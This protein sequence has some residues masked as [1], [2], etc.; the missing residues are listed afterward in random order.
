MFSSISVNRAIFKPG[1][2][3]GLSSVPVVNA[4]NLVARLSRHAEGVS[5][6]ENRRD[7]WFRPNIE[8]EDV[9]ASSLFFPLK[10]RKAR[11]FSAA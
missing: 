3:H 2:R 4:L 10:R 9:G 11:A 7:P 5:G 6:D 8:R 1:V